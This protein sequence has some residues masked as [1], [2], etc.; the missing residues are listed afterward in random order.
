MNDWLGRG[1]PDLDAIEMLA[2]AT[3]ND[4]PQQFAEAST[5]RYRAAHCRFCARRNPRGY[6]YR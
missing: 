3:L 1:A 6:G 2:R 4:L 5:K